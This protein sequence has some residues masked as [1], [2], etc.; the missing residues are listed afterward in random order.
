MKRISLSNI[1]VSRVAVAAVALLACMAAGPR[2]ARAQINYVEGADLANTGATALGVVGSGTNVVRGSIAPLALPFQSVSG[3]LADG[4]SVQV[5][6]GWHVTE[7]RIQVTAF[8]STVGNPAVFECTSGGMTPFNITASFPSSG[9]LV[10]APAGL[11]PGTHTFIVRHLLTSGFQSSSANI[12]YTITMVASTC[13]APQPQAIGE[14]CAIH[15]TFP[16]AG[17]RLQLLRSADGG[18]GSPFTTINAG[19]TD[20]VDHQPPGSTFTYR[21]ILDPADNPCGGTT[22]Y[23]SNAVTATAQLPSSPPRVTGVVADGCTLT[24]ANGNGAETVKLTLQREDTVAEIFTT[25]IPATA[26][27][28]SLPAGFD[29]FPLLAANRRAFWR[30]ESYRS[31]NGL[32]SPNTVEST[33]FSSV[34]TVVGTLGAPTVDLVNGPCSVL[35]YPHVSAGATSVSIRRIA[36]GQPVVTFQNPAMPFFEDTSAIPGVSYLYVID[37]Q[38]CNSVSGLGQILVTRGPSAGPRPAVRVVE[39][40]PA[41]LSVG[42]L[43]TGPAI[44]ATWRRGGQSPADPAS[45]PVLDGDG[46]GRFGGATTGTLMIQNVGPNDTDTYWCVLAHSCGSTVVSVNLFLTEGCGGDFNR[47]GSATVLDI[48]DFLTAWFAGC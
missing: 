15:L 12:S 4:F 30:I 47:S 5:P 23:V 27:P 43:P 39:G 7:V 21:A 1:A 37:A 11:L 3:D 26:I 24:W 36:A 29:P 31:C 10:T 45:R 44:S 9:N 32:T 6:V 20:F 14:E 16:P 34:F 25:T 35:V 42:A 33:T 8:N 17:P 18:F 41:A 2:A 48:F 22:S 28:Y 40:Q 13:S 19:Q 46:G 38:G